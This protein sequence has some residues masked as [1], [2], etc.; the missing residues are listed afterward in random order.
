[1][2]GIEKKHANTRRLVD[3]AELK[4]SLHDNF[5]DVEEAWRD[6]EENGHSF[7]FQNFAWQKSWHEF[8]AENDGVKP[9]L[10]VVKHPS[11]VPLMLFPL[12][13][14]RR[15]I[16]TCLVWL[17]GVLS[18]YQGPILHSNYSTQ[19][20]E[21]RF[22]A[23]WADVKA[24]L[25]RFDAVIFEKQPEYID[26]QKNPFISKSSQA[27]PSDA[28]YTELSGSLQSFVSSRRS[29]KSTSTEKR[30]ERRLAEHG[31]IK[32][33]VADNAADVDALLPV[34]MHQ[35]SA[36][37][38]KLGV[39]DLFDDVAIRKFVEHMSSHHNGSLV[40]LCG[41]MVGETVAATF[42]GLI[43]KRRLYY[44]LPAYE[45]DELTRFSPG[46]IQLRH[47]FDW[48]FRNTIRVFDFTVG[49][50]PYKK[51]WCDQTIKLFDDFEGASIKGLLY[52]Q[53]LKMQRKVKR[54]IKRS[55]LLS[56]AYLAMRAQKNAG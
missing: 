54:R 20:D 35:K 41:L 38:R 9:C 24:R 45:H 51:F 15:G 26:T 2:A 11:G 18:D 56:R 22:A 30:K 7:V 39:N 52:V 3:P 44:L 4:I 32:F 10:V 40:F 47:M 42:W 5:D 48:C 16:A 43:H 36:G 33:I 29:K 19:L 21:Q 23:I 28:H 12:G 53:I 8:V 13:F 6:L 14:Q 1:M 25:P 50:E 49:D 37:Y 31:E 34:L 46:N 27:H 55:P 17:G